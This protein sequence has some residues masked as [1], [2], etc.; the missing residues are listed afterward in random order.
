MLALLV[1]SIAAAQCLGNYQ[2]GGGT[3]RPNPKPEFYYGAIDP[4]IPPN[5]YPICGPGRVPVTGDGSYSWPNFASSGVPKSPYSYTGGGY[6]Y[7][8]LKSAAAPPPIYAYEDLSRCVCINKTI[9]ESP[10]PNGTVYQYLGPVSGNKRVLPDTL[11]VILQQTNAHNSQYGMVAIATDNSS[12]GRLGA[13]FSTGKSV[14]GCPNFNEVANPVDPTAN[15]ADPI[16]VRCEPNVIAHPSRVLTTFNAAS[17]DN[18][19]AS[20]VMNRSAEPLVQGSSTTL[21]SRIALPR[22]VNN[23]TML[24]VYQRRIWTCAQPYRLNPLNRQCE[25]KPELNACNGGDSSLGIPPSEM[26]PLITGHNKLEAYQNTVNKKLGACLNEFGGVGSTVKF[27][28]I[29]NSWMT[30]NNFNELW[31]ATD[32]SLDGGQPYAFQLLNPAGRPLTGFFKLS[33][34]RCDELSEFAGDIQPGQLS[35][36]G[37]SW[38]FTPKGNPILRP[39]ASSPGADELYQKLSAQGKRLPASAAEMAQCPLLARA[40]ILATCPKN[41]VLPIAPK[42]IEFR[43]S[44]NNLIERRCSVAS[45][46][47][48]HVRI[49]QVF[50]I[51]EQAPM[52]AF[53][54]FAENNQVTSISVSQITAAKYGT[55]CPPGTSYQNGIC[56]Y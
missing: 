14:C 29:D 12:D 52:R 49:E 54:T 1:P 51:A 37:A 7:S 20:I 56:I 42:T 48:V 33:G 53:D 44:S 6:T 9:P 36:S 50:E 38:V 15:P 5:R 34:E 3:C 26:H 47:Q 4:A 17:H 39:P 43:D 45:S 55:S 31:S 41:P 25:Y 22:A 2:M 13:L 40:A 24:D 21:V 19:S 27:D 46:I 10:L 30:F 23:Q 11:D 18:G 35:K 32:P 8:Y 28:C 16:G